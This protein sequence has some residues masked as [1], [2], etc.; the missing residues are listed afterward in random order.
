MH[1]R[2]ELGQ[3]AYLPRFAL[4][5]LLTFKDSASERLFE[6]NIHQGL[7]IRL[8]PLTL[9]LAAWP[10][11]PLLFTGFSA[12][13]VFTWWRNWPWTELLALS[14]VH[15]SLHYLDKELN[16]GLIVAVLCALGKH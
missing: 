4:T 9:A 12:F 11:S 5:W 15:C 8:L 7:L 6:L 14:L 1:F 2:A 13:L 3:K 16:A 10:G